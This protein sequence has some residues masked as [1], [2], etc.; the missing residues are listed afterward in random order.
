MRKLQMLLLLTISLLAG[1]GEVVIFG[2]T[3]REGHAASEVK[4][5]PTAAAVTE[6]TATATTA[7]VRTQKVRDVTL[8]LTPQAAE[9]VASDSRFNADAVRDA[10][11]S[12][13]QSRG[14]LDV[15]DATGSNT[16]STAAISIDDYAMSPTTNFVLFGSMAYSGTLSGSLV[17]RDAHGNE[18]QSHRVEAQARVSIPEGGD[19]GNSLR[20][21]YREFAVAA[22]NSLTGTQAKSNAALDERPR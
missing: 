8:S 5:A 11:K 16:S 9:K 4:A 18:L 6:A 13:L 10:I 21:L 12:E 17:L 2:H 15:G 3:V 20:S 22:V 14:L 7:D 19:T 1:C